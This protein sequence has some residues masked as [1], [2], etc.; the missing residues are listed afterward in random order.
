[1]DETDER[2]QHDKAIIVVTTNDISGYEVV[3]TFG[4]VFGVRGLAE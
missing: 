4:E 2:K 1:M 3:E